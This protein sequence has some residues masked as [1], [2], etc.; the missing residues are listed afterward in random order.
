M[1]GVA[2]PANLKQSMKKAVGLLQ[3]MS[4]EAG[5]EETINIL[6]KNIDG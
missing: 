4:T 5:V 3:S 1:L 2:A 6:Q